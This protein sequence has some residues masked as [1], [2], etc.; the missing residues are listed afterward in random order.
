MGVCGYGGTE[1]KQWHSSK[2]STMLHDD[3]FLY[4]PD[5]RV[6]DNNLRFCLWFAHH[7]DASLSADEK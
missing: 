7:D 6:D 1:Q 4:N 2:G 5:N 3:M